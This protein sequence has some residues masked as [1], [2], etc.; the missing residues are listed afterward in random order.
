MLILTRKLNEE[1][2]IRHPDG[3]EMLLRVHAIE[4][5]RVQFGF[6][7]PRDVKILRAE[8]KDRPPLKIAG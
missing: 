3:T 1:I 6:E 5:G 8:V 4:R 2:V 7:A